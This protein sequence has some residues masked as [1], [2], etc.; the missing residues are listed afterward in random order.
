MDGVNLAALG[1]TH[2]EGDGGAGHA[3]AGDPTQELEVGASVAAVAHHVD[4]VVY[5]VLQPV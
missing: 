1:L 3:A 4:E 5:A 2:C